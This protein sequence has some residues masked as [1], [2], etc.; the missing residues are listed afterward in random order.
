MVS[1][2]SGVNKFSS[3]SLSLRRVIDLKNAGTSR[4]ALLRRLGG[5][6][7]AS[8]GYRSPSVSFIFGRLSLN[9][10]RCVGMP[11]LSLPIHACGITW[12][13]VGINHLLLLHA[14]NS[15]RATNA[16][17]PP[18]QDGLL[19]DS[20]QLSQ[21]LLAAES[22]QV[23]LSAHGHRCRCDPLRGIERRRV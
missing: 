23:A 3:V 18:V 5:L 4:Y 19:P 21:T 8:I 1:P 2:A 11:P 6:A 10:E 22:L 12:G 7:A 14:V 16:S 13:W 20:D 15:S 9:N 17:A